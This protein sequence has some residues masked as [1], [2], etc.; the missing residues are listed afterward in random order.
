MRYITKTF[1]VLLVVML[2]AVA[3]AFL[4]TMLPIPGNIEIKIVKSGSMTPAIPTGSLIVVM[5]EEVY[6]VG[7]VVTFGADTKTQIPT[8]HRI[9]SIEGEGKNQI[10]TTKG[11]A[12]EEADGKTTRFTEIIGKV[13]FHLPYA[14]Y[15]LDFARQ[16][17]GF[18]LLIGLPAL[19]IIL[20]ELVNIFGEVR[21]IRRKPD[22]NIEDRV[23]NEVV[24]QRPHVNSDVYVK[25]Q[26]MFLML[27]AGFGLAASVIMGTAGSTIS[28]FSDFEHSIGNTFGAGE[29]PEFFVQLDTL[30]PFSLMS[31]DQPLVAG[32]STDATSTPETLPDPT[33]S[34]T[35]P[36]VDTPPEP[37]QASSTP[38]EATSTPPVVEPPP[39]EASSTPPVEENTTEEIPTSEGVGIPT[40][41]V[42]NNDTPPQ[43]TEE[44]PPES[45]PEG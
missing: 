4:S 10:F 42:G 20:D 8:T 33:A 19:F 26:K 31:L 17:W 2:V 5:P 6:Q 45:P 14:G 28:Y 22:N 37:P 12:N 11:D 21:R 39:T 13:V 29:W 15:V 41:S 43:E 27:L 24:V 3:G 7:E 40:E 44:A 36:V 32:T 34:S 9:V 16:P 35:P 25:A 18:A 23:L 30:T 1:N 38:P